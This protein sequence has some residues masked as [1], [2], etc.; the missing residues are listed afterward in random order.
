MISRH[1][2]ISGKHIQ[3]EQL[4]Y[5]CEIWN[6]LSTYMYRESSYIFGHQNEIFNIIGGTIWCKEP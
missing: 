5:S 4:Q 2:K 1:S 3:S 6:I